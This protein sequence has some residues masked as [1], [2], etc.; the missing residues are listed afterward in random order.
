MAVLF[1]RLS[2]HQR[3]S[4]IR[5]ISQMNSQQNASYASRRLRSKQT[6]DQLVRLVICLIPGLIIFGA[7]LALPGST[8]VNG[9][10]E[11][12]APTP[13]MGWNSWDGYGTTINEEQFR[14]NA[15]WMARHLKPFGWQYAVIDME[16][17]VKNPVP[18]GNSKTSEYS[19]DD[20]GRYT[21]PASRFPSAAAGVGFKQIADYTHSLGLK[22]GIHIL[23]GIPKQAVDKNLPIA[24]SKYH[25][26]DAAVSSDTCPWN[27]DDY[28]V[29]PS[30]PAGQAYYDSIIRLYAQWGVDF[31]KVDCISF[32][33]Y[34]EDEI[35]SLSEAIAKT[36]RPIVLSL[37]PGPS[38]LDK[39]PAFRKYSQMWRISNDVWDLWHNDAVYP[40]GVVDQ[41]EYAARWASIPEQGH[42]P[43]A[44][45]LPLGRLG[46][47]PGWGKPR[48][49]ALTHDEQR[50][51]VSLW[52]ISRSPLMVGGD[53]SA[54]DDWTT[55][56]LTNPEVLAV[57]QH[58]KQARQVSA[59]P[60]TVVWESQSDSGATTYLALFNLAPEGRQ[61]DRQWKE[62][63]LSSRKYAVRDLWER[64]DLGKMEAIH[65]TLPSHGA[66]L[67]RLVPEPKV[68]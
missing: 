36:G 5:E 62:L 25:A 17:F 7:V 28:G 23:R 64:K 2:F 10:R 12:L 38:P 53:L 60:D 19:I 1:N 26:A 34:K 63:D 29:D 21:P 68:R 32:R 66:V 24:G 16:W 13:P 20:Y 18:E 44:D 57:D 33:P 6:G 61:F 35:R 65:V 42:W 4:Q 31:I 55:Q 59:T 15:D 67:Y 52:C 45:M 27:F 11:V 9:G 51:L 54:A 58:A 43:D 49:T 41:F 47:Q 22:F 14:A 3:T 46:P 39:A 56:L 37:S 48:D 30:R 50:T 8:T 40:K